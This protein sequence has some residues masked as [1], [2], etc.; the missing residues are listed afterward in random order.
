MSLRLAPCRMS[1][2]N[3]YVRSIHRH[4]GPLPAAI[5]AVAV[6]SEPDAV[7]RGVAV[8]GIPKARMLMARGT[9]EVSRVATDGSRNACSML[10]GAC[11]RAAKALGYR[12]LITYTL[13]S[14]AGSSLRASGWS[15]VGSAG[16]GSW[17]PR[18]ADRNPAYVDTHDTGAK[19]RWEISLGNSIPDLAWT[20][21]GDPE[22]DLF[23]ESA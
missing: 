5:F 10:Y 4:N 13:E 17:A 6:Y 22:P 19:W 1:E 7:V 23:E 3:D 8:A 18:N 2:A 11:T 20:A 21:P 14:E 15:I 16:G 9:L 12:R